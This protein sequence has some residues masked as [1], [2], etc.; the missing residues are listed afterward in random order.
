MQVENLVEI[1]PCPFCNSS[2]LLLNEKVRWKSIMCK[3][4]CAE[5]GTGST[6]KEALIKW[7]RRGTK[8]D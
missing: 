6:E 2:K 7:N 4:C 1:K 5:G 3:D 8:N